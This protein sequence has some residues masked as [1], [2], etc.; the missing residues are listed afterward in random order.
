MTR[1]SH[2]RLA[3]ERDL[4]PLA[5]LEQ[6]AFEKDR[7]TEEQIDYL[8][9]RSR[10]T[11]FVLELGSELVGAAYVLYRKAYHAAR[12]Y[13]LAVDPAYQGSGFGHRLLHECELEAARR[14]CSEITLE[15]RQ[16]NE[17]GVRFYQRHGYVIRRSMS[18]YYEDGTAGYKMAKEIRLKVPPRVS[19]NIP[20]HAQTLDFTCGAACVM[21]ALKY[22]RPQ[23][24]LTRTLEMRI[25]KEATLVFML[26]GYAGTDPFGLSLSCVDRGLTCRVMISLDTT[27]LLM[28][29][30]TAKKREIMKVVH[31]DMMRQ[32]RKSGVH[33]VICEYGIEEI[34]SA[35]YR[36]L[37]PIALISTYRLTGD[38]VP[39]W[40]VVTG[41]ERDYLY[42]HDPD[43]E[44]YKKN[45]S[46]ARHLRI[47][48]SE[49]LR[50]SRYGKEVYRCLLLTGPP[51]GRISRPRPGPAA[52]G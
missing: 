1:R 23:Q 2:I 42:I 11:L 32:A 39:H 46:R 36:G 21:M 35:L 49:F 20:Y 47:R 6:V 17:G 48:K 5:R 14:S 26:S 29:V 27:P 31:S 13:N 3:T 41:C 10:A 51:S 15:V 7:F 16:D 22:F 44:S 43:L 12:L 45:K 8:M 18:D 50:M 30:R 37:V 34:V 52:V 9:G 38:Q 33:R 25:W 24:E 28:S 40:V 19:L 4:K